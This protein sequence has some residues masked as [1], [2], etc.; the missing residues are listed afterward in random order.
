MCAPLAIAAGAVVVAGVAQGV[1]QKG[2]ADAS[3]DAQRRNAILSDQ[4]ASHALQRGEEDAGRVQLQGNSL[5]GAQ[6]AGYGTS[7]ADVNSGSAAQTQED[8]AWL[9]ELDK[10]T[11]RNNAQREAWGLGKQ[12]DNMRKSASDTAGAGNLA[13]GASIIGGVGN[14]AVLYHSETARPP[15]R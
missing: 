2:A 5:Q 7:G 9:T 15:G 11:M 3:A 4:A 1:A 6:R 13:L 14:A 8:T 10:Q 12:A